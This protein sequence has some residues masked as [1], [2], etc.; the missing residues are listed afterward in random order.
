MK[1]KALMGGLVAIIGLFS[2]SMI[3]S[4]IDVPK[5]VTATFDSKYPTAQKVEWEL[6]KE[7]EY[8]AEFK[9]A[10]KEMSA[11]F[12]ADGTWLETE[13]EIKTEAL[14]QAVKTAITT[15]FPSYELEEAE[16]VEKPEAAMA[17][18]VKLE[19]EAD[20]TEIEAVF[21]A[22]GT[23]LKKEVKQEEDDDNDDDDDDKGDNDN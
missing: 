20:D 2:I 19:N 11:N 14:P 13:M 1:I 16:Q 7:G 9:I 10:K 4:K 8:E 23:L 12:L 18:E 21:S 6:E 15:L 5:A 22:D 17:Y 3:Q